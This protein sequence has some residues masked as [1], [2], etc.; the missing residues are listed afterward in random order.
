MTNLKTCNVLIIGSGP[1]GY[2]AA[3]YAA[4]ANLQPVVVEGLQAGGQLTSTTNVENY[5]GFADPIQGPWLME[6]MRQ[7]ALNVGVELVGDIV[8]GIDTST[9]PFKCT[10]DSGL[11]YAARTVI[12]STGAQA[13]WLGLDSEAKFNGRGVSACAT[14]DGFFFRN[15]RVA[16][17]GGGNTAVEEALYL[18]A[19][20]NEVVLVHRRDTLRAEKVL[21][22]RLQAKANISVEWNKR[23]DEILGDDNGVNALALRDTRTGEQSRIEVDGVFVA[24]GHSPSTQLL[25]GKVEIDNDGYVLTEPGTTRT[26][27]PG[28]FAAGDVQDKTYRQAITAAGTGCMAALDAE[29]FLAGVAH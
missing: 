20:C 26:S 25:T 6:Q 5:S 24:I 14:C 10:T 4:R 15:R 1:A 18:S 28:L 21:Q 12:V 11:T 29:H 19:I 9:R 22:D 16:V 17:V 3:I 27:L 8:T 2:T 13:K 23:V 7:Q